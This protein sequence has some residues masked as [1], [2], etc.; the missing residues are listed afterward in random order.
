MTYKRCLR[1][2]A[3]VEMLTPVCRRCGAARWGPDTSPPEKPSRSPRLLLPALGLILVAFW[4][5]GEWQY[6]R[7]TRQHAAE[8]SALEEQQ[9]AEDASLAA[10]IQERASAA[11]AAHKKLLA[12]T[13]FIQGKVGA[14]ARNAEWERR[15]AH[16]PALATTVF[17]TNLLRMSRLGADP[18]VSAR[19]AL[20][21]VGRLSSPPGSR[22]EVVPSGDQ[23]VV[24][25]AF[26]MSALASEETGAVTKHKSNE[27]MRREVEEISA[28]VL[29]DLFDSCGT[30]G[31]AKIQVSC[32]HAVQRGI[33]PSEATESERREI[34][35]R[36][37][38]VMDKLYRMSLDAAGARAIGD[39]RRLPLS[40]LLRRMSVE[41]DGFN[42]LTINPSLGPTGDPKDP[43]TPLQ[44]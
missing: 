2:S 43:N 34:M 16:D 22:V 18:R 21:E 32:N 5:R 13:E 28:R 42:A 36:S 26:K 30:R 11:E 24:R 27:S 7:L 15:L 4:V 38:M 44:F 29:R 1:C 10:A 25:V 6:S 8:R 12:D 17:E 33:V 41:F 14:R 37:S 19:E 9:A 35:S 3:L 20:T 39:W 40:E 31:I 23:F